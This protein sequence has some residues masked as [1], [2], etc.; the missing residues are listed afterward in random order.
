M[1]TARSSLPP[2]GATVEDDTSGRDRLV[3]LLLL[4]SAFTVILNETIM[5]V[6]L[7]RLM[8]DL[9]LTASQG[10][11]LTTSF[12]LTMAVVI[13]VTGFLLQRLHTR[14]VF[15]MAMGLFSVGTLL[16]ATAP[17]LG[18]LITGRIVQASGTAIMMP[19]LMTTVM[20]LVPPENR[21]RTMGNISIVISVAPA[22]GPTVSGIILSLLDWRW[23]FW[24]V[25][26]IGLGSLAIGRMWLQNVTEPRQAPLDLLSVPL[27]AIG[28]GGVVYGLSIIG[29][30]HGDADTMP[31][32]LPLA[33]GGA[34]LAVFVRRQLRL[35]PKGR[36]LLDLR[37][38]RV[39]VF[40]V[41]VI[42]MGFCMA[43]LFGMIILLPIYM[44]NVLG[45]APVQAGLLLLPGGLIMGLLAPSVGRAYD[46]IGARRLVIPGTVF[47]CAGL[48]SMASLGTASA[49]WQVLICHILLSIGLA[50]LFT[51]L[52]TA[53]LSSLPKE[54]YS[55]GSA[56]LGTTQQVAGAAGI[57]LFVSVMSLRIAAAAEAGAAPIEAM[58]EGVRAGFV[59]GGIMALIM[60]GFSF[61]V[62]RPPAPDPL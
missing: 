54:L 37:T 5:G 29:E 2:T 11:W 21:G 26:P 44:Q 60:I 22:I 59:A 53:S 8:H 6:A 50:L 43:A 10:Q 47:L 25:L 58:A 3:I 1:S 7:P 34:A 49:V 48:W 33:V 57:A 23:M 38:F 56:V 17:G 51:P 32:W 9:D 16:C 42:M 61:M 24:L 20:T 18:M 36:A 46:R 15:T 13:P 12:L 30:G 40:R 35:G 39:P 52:F 55:Y 28:F 27:S 31:L 14:T 45:M 4:I 62:R 19:L 41:A